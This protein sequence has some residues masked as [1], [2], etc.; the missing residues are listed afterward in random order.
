MEQRFIQARLIELGVTIIAGQA[1]SAVAADGLVTTC[2]YTGKEKRHETA[3]IVLVTSRRPEDALYR[4]LKER[5][6]EVTAIGDAWVPGG[7]KALATM[8]RLKV[9]PSYQNFFLEYCRA[10]SIEMPVVF[11]LK[12]A[13]HTTRPNGDADGFPSG[14]VAGAMTLAT[15]LGEHFGLYP[16][17]AGYTFAGFV[18]F[19]RIHEIA[20]VCGPILEDGE[21]LRVRVTFFPEFNL[22][23]DGARGQ[24]RR[25]RV[26]GA[27]RGP[28]VRVW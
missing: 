16:A 14:H 3:S 12:K 26:R 2:I 7:I 11:V 6:A 8:A 22:L 27:R 21:N 25:G 20:L 9:T 15:L 24:R 17:I 4:A 28:A 5:G 13:F 10:I 18:A 23:S 1:L 19:H